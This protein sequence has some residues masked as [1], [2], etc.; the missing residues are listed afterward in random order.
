MAEDIGSPAV[1]WVFALIVVGAWW[2]ICWLIGVHGR[3]TKKS[4]GGIGDD[5]FPHNRRNPYVL[6]PCL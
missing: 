3:R 4:P 2:G 6:A 5:H 1:A